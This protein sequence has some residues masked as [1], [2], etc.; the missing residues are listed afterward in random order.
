MVHPVQT[1]SPDARYALTEQRGGHWR[2]KHIAMLYDHTSM[3]QL[4]EQRRRPDWA[5]A[6][7]NSY[8]T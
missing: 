2:E 5:H 1:G 6:L 8:M 4:A 3:A 7:R